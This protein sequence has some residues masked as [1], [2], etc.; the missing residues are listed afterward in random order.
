[1]F[2]S[3]TKSD[4]IAPS[5]SLDKKVSK[6]SSLDKSTKPLTSY[7]GGKKRGGAVR[8][9]KFRP[10]LN[11]L[12]SKLQRLISARG[13]SRELKVQTGGSERVSNQV[14]EP[15][16]V[17]AAQSF[18]SLNQ[19]YRFRLGG[20][21]TLTQ[22]TGVVNSFFACD[23]SAAGINFPE[24]STL[25]ALF[26]EFR[27]V[28]LQ[29]QFVHNNFA[30]TAFG[31][32][33][34]FGPMIVAGNLGT[35]VAP[36]SYAN[37]ADNADAVLWDPRATNAYGIKHILHGHGIGWSEV[38]TPTVTPYAGAP[39]SIQIYGNFGS[40]SQAD[41]IHCLISGIYEFRSRV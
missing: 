9:K 27:L 34:A 17:T 25:T 2:S 28:S 31:T 29:I 12:H 8:V 23:P 10:K 13:V 3:S 26:S 20:H 11:S 38:T 30:G 16:D 35:A 36:G 6:L 41:V 1:M 4:R 21:T 19:V 14:Y 32:S 39:G 22:T 37:L 40:S 24:W 33:S 15:Q 18:V 5:K 7:R